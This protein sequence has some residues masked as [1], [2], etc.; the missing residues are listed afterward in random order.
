VAFIGWFGPRGLASI[1]FA[2]IV[3]EELAETP[4]ALDIT[5]TVG[6]TVVLSVVA[7]GMTAWP[8]AGRYGAWF[9]RVSVESPD[10]MEGAPVSPVRPRG[11]AF[12]PPTST[13]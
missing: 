13:W 1:V 2:V 10:L 9:Q 11:G 12:V 7:H 6:I 3:L 5:V 4:S 8:L